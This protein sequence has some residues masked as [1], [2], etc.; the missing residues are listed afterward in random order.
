MPPVEINDFLQR[1][2]CSVCVFCCHQFV[3]G[4][5]DASVCE[6]VDGNGDASVCENVGQNGDASVREN[7]DG[8]DDASV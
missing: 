4:D 3:D 5:G 1:V 2:V 6:N 8:N 7:V